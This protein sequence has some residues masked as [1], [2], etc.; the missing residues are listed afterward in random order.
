MSAYFLAASRRWAA[1]ACGAAFTACTVGYTAST[2][3]NPNQTTGCCKDIMSWLQQHRADINGLNIR[4]SQSAGMGVFATDDL[5]A[6]K[7]ASVIWR[8]LSRIGLSL[9]GM[10]LASFPTQ[11]IINENTIVTDTRI[12]NIIESSL[13]SG[14]LDN[15]GAL[16]L[17]LLAHRELGPESEYAPYIA[18]LSKPDVPIAYPENV[19]QE[20]AGTELHAA[21]QDLRA[22]LAKTWELVKPLLREV[23]VACQKDMDGLTLEDWTWAFSIL[24][25]RS[26]SV[27]VVAGSEGSA[28]MSLV[29]GLDYLNHNKG[30]VVRWAID[31][32]VDSK[33]GKIKLKCPSHMIPTSG[34]EVC[35]QYSQ[36]ASNFTL[37]LQYGFVDEVN[38]N[39]CV[40]ITYPCDAPEKLQTDLMKT[41]VSLLQAKNLPL[42]FFLP[43]DGGM[44]GDPLPKTGHDIIKVFTMS[45]RSITEAVEHPLQQ[46]PVSLGDELAIY[47]TFCWLLEQYQLSMEGPQGTGSLA[48]DIEIIQRGPDGVSDAYWNC[49]VYRAGQKSIVRKYLKASRRKLQEIMDEMYGS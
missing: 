20:L 32:T 45:A 44:R 35:I 8:T 25:S 26:F 29:P 22:K 6:R 48:E 21:V 5:D 42:Q 7:G 47:T 46:L 12:G 17:W 49:V 27:P 37:L 24:T 11:L 10:T 31:G 14:K 13:L 34:E 19:F 23:G 30:S 39:D 38:D 9:G 28:V 36:D 40:R 2:C 43:K 16:Q 1:L 3:E 41:R 4:V 18:S 33:D 15:V